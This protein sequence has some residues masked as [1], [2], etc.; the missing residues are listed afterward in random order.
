M[1]DINEEVKDGLEEWNNGEVIFRKEVA[2]GIAGQ[3][4]R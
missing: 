1:I 4:R 3:M 2:T